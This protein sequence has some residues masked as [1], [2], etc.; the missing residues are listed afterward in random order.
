[1]ETVRKGIWFILKGNS[2]N[3][4]RKGYMQTSVL[5]NEIIYAILAVIPHCISYRFENSE[6]V[7]FIQAILG[8]TETEKQLKMMFFSPIFYEVML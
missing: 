3:L 1:M 5:F 2:K 6:T 8:N 7:S 4:S